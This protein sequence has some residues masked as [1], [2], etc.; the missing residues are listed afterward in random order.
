MIAPRFATGMTTITCPSCLA[1]LP[2]TAADAGTMLTCAACGDPCPV[3]G[4]AQALPAARTPSSATTPGAAANPRRAAP[5]P[6]AAPAFVPPPTA[7]TPAGLPPAA[8]DRALPLDP[9]PAAHRSS[10]EIAR[11]YL[12][13]PAGAAARPRAHA[14]KYLGGL[15]RTDGFS[16]FCHAFA[17]G[18]GVLMTITTLGIDRSSPWGVVCCAL[19]WPPFLAITLL[20]W[21]YWYH[22]AHHGALQYRRKIEF[23]TWLVTVPCMAILDVHWLAIWVIALFLLFRGARRLQVA[24]PSADGPAPGAKTLLVD[25]VDLATRV[26]DY[27]TKQAPPPDR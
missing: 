24:P 19:M 22:G 11:D 21:A 10:Q 17:L 26:R 6:F 3:P 1:Q 8:H 20:P 7:P 23:A 18:W 12:A 13:A 27:Y 2:I 14:R 16:L 4:A 15:V 9:T 5:A 25:D